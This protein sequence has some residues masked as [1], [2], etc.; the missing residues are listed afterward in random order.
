MSRHDYADWQRVNL[1]MIAKILAELEYERTLQAEE[2]DGQ[3][4]IALGDTTYR[5]SAKR[6]IWGWLHIDT[7]SLSCDRLPLAA[8]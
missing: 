1:Q 5:F 8:D 7:N 2:H 6:G 4:Q 3:W